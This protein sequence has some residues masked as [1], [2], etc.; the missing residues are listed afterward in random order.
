MIDVQKLNVQVEILGCKGAKKKKKQFGDEVVGW[1]IFR[2][3]VYR[4][5]DRLGALAANDS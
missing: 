5:Y 4:C 1:A 2:W 3:A